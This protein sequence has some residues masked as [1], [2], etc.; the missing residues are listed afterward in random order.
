MVDAT[1]EPDPGTAA[2]GG[3]RGR[4][5]LIWGSEIPFRNLHFTGR[6]AELQALR[7]QLQSGS[8]AVIRQPPS[9][10]FGLGGVGK[11]QIA[12]EY[13]HRYAHEYEV[14]WWV[15]ADQEDSIQSSLVA[16]GTRLRLPD[17]SP[18]DRDR[19]LRAVIDALQAGNPS[20]QWLLIYDDVREP[21][22][23]SRYVPRGGHV[24]VT[25]RI[26]E[27]RQV[28]STDGIEVKE[29]ARADTVK[30]LRDRV[31]QL[32]PGG[33]LGAGPEAARAEVT[34]AALADQ[35]A[36]VLGDLPLAAE[37]AASYLSQTGMPVTE[38]IEAFQRDAHT[39]L[40]LDVDMFS[41]NLAVATTWSVSRQ[42]LTPE[43]RE[44]FQLLAFFAAEPISEENLIQPGRVAL[45]PDLPAPLAKVLSSRTELK[46]A[47]RELARFSLISIYGQ[48]NVV[49]MH[50]VVQA[51]TKARIEKESKELASTLRETVFALLA[52]SDPESP[53]R[54]QND[55]VYERSIHHLGPTGALESGNKLLRNLIINQVRRLRMRAGFREALSLGE[56]ALEF[57][58]ADPD[59][60]QTL[61]MAVEVAIVTRLLGRV[62]EAFALNSETLSRLRDTY[63]E[64][65]DTYLICA[66]SYGEDLRL[67]GRYDDALALDFS[68]RPAYEE[69]F[70]P[71]QFRPLSLRN[72]I[73]I[74]FRC[75]GRFAEALEYDSAVA[76]ERERYFGTTDWQTASSKFGMARDLRRLGRYEEALGLARELA[77][78]M[79]RRNEPWNFLRLDIFAGLSVSLRRVG[80]Y[81][82]A[83]DLA[84]EVYRR[85]VEFAGEQHRATLV[86]AT[87]LMCDR[88]VVDD[89]ASAEVLGDATVRAWEKVAGPGHPNTLNARAN[90]AVILRMRGNPSAALELNEAVVQGSHGLF[91]YEHEHP[92]T[93]I[94]M[95]NL[96][97]DL[98]A[99]GDVRR[100]REIG[101]QVIAA[102][103]EVR[104]LIHPATLAASA[105]LVLDLRATGA[106]DEARDLEARTL[107]AYDELLSPEHP[108]ALRARQQG[109]VN[110]DIEPAM[111]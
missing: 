4:H 27:W 70:S 8:A 58:Q 98:A 64:H 54:E 104:G 53:E 96:A 101:E 86:M 109:R 14:V 73:A 17:V 106:F 77:D 57:W 65:D 6:E 99:V 48:R 95:T 80:Y 84:E 79:E 45:A 21:Q 13:A 105:N 88:R 107:A 56:A 59:D 28:L 61:A 91:P 26:N 22:K 36:E 110:V 97:S 43:A 39:L 20:A 5:T 83:R 81:G 87:N 23:L 82:E 12:T 85:Y 41:A 11:T 29:F 46:R 51:V 10:L 47:Q 33:D 92:N 2:A 3:G 93:L 103:R 25:S 1:P 16:L 63:G 30:F 78:V 75:V 24:I 89:L 67:L 9:A 60:I 69:V 31:P 55:P 72:N 32:A 44:L 15:R 94:A 42:T 19:A 76:V 108:Q 34:S 50:R 66:M 38:Y 18:G 35:L 68:L 100:A 40:G 7:A 102:S 52:A 62:D 71:G 49:Q 74:D 90:L 37:H 111:I